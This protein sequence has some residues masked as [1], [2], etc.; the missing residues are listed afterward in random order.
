MYRNYNNEVACLFMDI[1]IIVAAHKEFQ[2]PQ[3][4]I[5]L[6]LH[7][8]AAGKE[9][10]IAAR[11]AQKS[12]DTVVCE[13][14]ME[15]DDT[16]DN[17]SQ[18]NPMYCELT[19]L[20]W[21]WKNLDAEYCGLV[22]YRRHFMEYPSWLPT[23]HPQRHILGRKR[24]ESLLAETDIILPKK[25]NYYITNIHD[26]YAASHYPEHLTAAREVIRERCPEYLEAYDAL[27]KSTKA[28][29]FNM[30]I[31]R[32]DKL[33]AYCEW[34]FPLLYELENRIDSSSYDAFQAR[35]PGRLSELL[36]NVW[37]NKNGLEYKEVPVRMLGR[38][39]WLRKIWSFLC[40]K[41]FKKQ[42]KQ[43]F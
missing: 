23:C 40:A 25:R 2:M 24:L 29:M 32:R 35:Y 26:H 7:V 34:L 10:L 38:V 15:R 3:E 41:V 14:R 30:M 43:G 31:M 5:Y 28:H 39:R 21:M 42:Y 16:G 6:P 27:M 36:L 9:E 4:D 33:E 17:I 11:T 22:H 1:K 37:I 18:K 13:E 8:G 20:Y 19:G 12:K